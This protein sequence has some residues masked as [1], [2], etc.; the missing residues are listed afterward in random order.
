MIYTTAIAENHDTGQAELVELPLDVDSTSGLFGVMTCPPRITKDTGF[1]LINAG[2]LHR[3]GPFRLYVDI[4]RR[5]AGAG[6]PSIRL[7]LSGKG[8]S[9][10][11]T[12]VSLAEAT[13]A[14]VSAAAGRLQRETGVKQFVIGGLCSGADDA[15]QVAGHLDGIAGLLMFDGFAPKTARYYVHR[16]APKLFSAESWLSRLRLS[17]GQARDNGG[18]IGNL[19]NWGTPREMMERYRDLVDQGTH[20]LAIF[21]G[22]G[23]NCYAYPS[24]LTTAIRHPQAP[25]LV[26]ELHFPDATHLFHMSE[27]RRMAVDGI[28]AWAD[29]IFPDKFSE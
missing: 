19:R 21:S 13:M 20:V 4:A 14:N 5:I 8:D 10:A 26:S 9:D 27:H 1:I 15:L 7:D 25:A 17:S 28:A 6:F 16:Y 11:L 24:Q 3:V 22:W 29:R 2:L 18:E 23:G 12:G